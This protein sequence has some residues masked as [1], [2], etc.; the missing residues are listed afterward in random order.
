[1]V[2]P[3][4]TEFSK[5][6][7]AAFLIKSVFALVFFLWNLRK[8]PLESRVVE[9]GLIRNLSILLVIFN[10]P[11][12][13][14]LLENN[15]NFLIWLTQSVNLVFPL[16]LLYFWLC[17]FERGDLENAARKSSVFSRKSNLLLVLLLAAFSL[18]MYL[19]KSYNHLKDFTGAVP[20]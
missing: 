8:I 15:T 18:A 2:N 17:V 3:E 20:A 19:S 6:L 11:F 10:C 4:F 16:A 7:R 12:I 9:H 14:G 13:M 1:M 5:G